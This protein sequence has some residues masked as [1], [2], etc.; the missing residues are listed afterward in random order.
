[1]TKSEQDSLRSQIATLENRRGKHSKY[2]PFAFTEHGAVM[3]ASVLNSK[4]AVEASIQV[5]RAFV[6]LREVL[7]THKE[8][9]AKFQ[10]LEN[11][12]DKHDHEIHALFEAIRQ[13]METPNPP[14]K[15][16]GYK[17]YDAGE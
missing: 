12:F 4:V 5:V 6:K 2:L 7:S 13:L 14:R 15:K 3:L 16:I 11:K 1:L 9:A 8:L 17:S 10:L